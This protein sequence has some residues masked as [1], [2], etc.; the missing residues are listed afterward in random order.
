[1]STT[2]C[3]QV[4]C[5]AMK[6]NQECAKEGCFLECKGK[7]C[8]QVCS[9][10]GGRCRM[11]CHPG[12]ETCVQLCPN[13]GCVTEC[14]AKKCVQL[15][16]RWH[17]TT[18]SNMFTRSPAT[19]AN[20]N[21]TLDVLSLTTKS[22][23]SNKKFNR[24]NKTG[25]SEVPTGSTKTATESDDVIWPTEYRVVRRLSPQIAHDVRHIK[26]R[27]NKLYCSFKLVLLV[28]FFCFFMITLQ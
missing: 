22:F 9:A 23:S 1:M 16:Q 19:T 25:I 4:E 27:S 10:P 28:P 14:R 18:S 7:H 26:S 13:G 3:R 11:T 2:E 12:V 20:V 6:C 15:S 24:T 17:D 8:Y 5:S 21:T